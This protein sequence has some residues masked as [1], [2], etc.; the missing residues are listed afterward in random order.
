M[1]AE[2]CYCSLAAVAAVRFC[3]PAPLSA[4]QKCLCKQAFL[5]HGIMCEKPCYCSLAAV[6]AVRFCAPAPLSASQ[7]CLC[8]QAF[9][10]HGIIRLVD[11]TERAYG[12]DEKYIFARHHVFG[13]IRYRCGFS[14]K[15]GNRHRNSRYRQYT[16][17]IRR[18]GADRA[19]LPL[20]RGAAL[21]WAEY[22]R[23]FK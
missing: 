9:L 23:R 7:K 12:A 4:S 22:R 18:P 5:L 19:C 13:N 6:A 20:D 17:H 10:L 8:K 1:C 21:G 14:Q 2:A 3:A 16:C 15:Q 11:Y